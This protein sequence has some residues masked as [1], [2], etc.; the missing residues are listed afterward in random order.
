MKALIPNTGCAAIPIL[1]EAGEKLGTLDPISVE[2][3]KSAEVVDALTR[4]R[5]MFM[6]YFLTQFHAT[7]ER[8]TVWLENQILPDDTR[9]LFL[10]RCDEGRAV[11]NFGVCDIDVDRAELDNLVR[12]E[13]GG[14]ARL[15]YYSE[16]ALM[17]WLYSFVGVKRI[18]LHVFSTNSRTIALHKSV[19]FEEQCA[20]PLAKTV[21]DT[22]VRYSVIEASHL[23]AGDLAYVRFEMTN[24][25]F[26]ARHTWVPS[27]YVESVQT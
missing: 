9:I 18:R 3:G 16:I 21:K 22:D 17:H 19:G 25:R 20:F 4:W 5:R 7:P 13:R 11:G 27:V 12:G 1:G 8:T 2:L 15:V 10:L 14:D 26:Y 24:E 6:R 23:R